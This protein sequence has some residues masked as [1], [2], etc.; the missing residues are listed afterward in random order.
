M[1]PLKN[2]FQNKIL[3]SPCFL[4]F[5]G[6]TASVVVP[7][8]SGLNFQNSITVNLWVKPS[9]FY[10]G[11]EQYII[12]HGN[13]QNRWKLSVTPGSNTLRWTVR[14]TTMVTRDLDSSSPLVIDSLMNVTVR[15]DGA[16]MEIYINGALDAFTGFSGPIN[17]TSYALT[18]GQD[19]PL[20][21]QYD[22]KGVLD[23]VRI[24]NYGLSPGQISSLYDIL[25]GVDPAAP[26][27][28]PL[29]FSLFQNYPNPFNPSTTISFTVPGVAAS[30]FVSLRVYDL[31]GRE[32]A[33][34]ARGS[35]RGG[36]YSMVWDGS[37][38]SS[39]IYICRLESGGTSIARKMILMR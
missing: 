28:R 32:V 12:S 2:P 16:D 23:D 1:P 5:D 37:Q 35:F 10:A 26:S 34:L 3:V 4:A 31:L 24:Y 20:D 25:N 7:N 17:T 13:W 8:D 30:Q 29:V 21:N 18:V 36:Q 22:F 6:S 11:R 38:L 15:Y 33:T 9:A 27:P 39:G 19:L 14:N